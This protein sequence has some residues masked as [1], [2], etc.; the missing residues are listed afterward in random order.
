MKL[1]TPSMQH[2][3]LFLDAVRRSRT[4][5]GRWVSPPATLAQY[6]EFVRR[7]SMPTHIGHFVCTP[8]GALAGVINVS[9]IVRGAFCSAYIGYYALAPHDGR[10][11]MRDGLRVV[12]GLAFKRYALHRLE[13]NIQPDNLRSR[14]LVKSLGFRLEGYSPRYLKI[15]GRW[16]DHERWAIT[17][18]EWP[19]RRRATSLV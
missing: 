14:V 3:R 5:H 16:R 4:L 15:R 7:F 12:I 11:Y 6:R 17:A 1:E 2:T 13:A 19:V 18:E 10:G 8:E 9:E